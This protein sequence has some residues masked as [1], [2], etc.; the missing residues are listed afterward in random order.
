MET[1]IEEIEEKVRL[2][3]KTEYR[4][5][6]LYRVSVFLSQF[7]DI[8]KF[9]YHSPEYN[10]HA[11]SVGVRED[12]ISIYGEAM[13]HLIAL[14]ISR[15]IKVADALRAGIQRLEDKDGYKKKGKIVETAVATV[16]KGEFGSPGIAQGTALVMPFVSEEEIL[17]LRKDAIDEKRILVAESLNTNSSSF[18]DLMNVIAIVTNQGGQTSHGAKI[19]REKKIPCVTA[20]EVATEIIK[21]GDTIIVDGDKREVVLRHME[22]RK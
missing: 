6:A 2:F 8:A 17:K 4:T 9:V 22:A 1:S 19:A 10:P 5:D 18:L 15:D 21:S 11:R 20:A 13:W 3:L 14:M 7:G 12:E 16:L